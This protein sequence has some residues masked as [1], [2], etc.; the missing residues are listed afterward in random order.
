MIHKK[1]ISLIIPC[2]NEEVALYAML[3]K[4]PSFVDE[5]LVVDN[6]STDNTAFIAKTMGAKVISEKRT[7]N[8]V[9]YG[10]AHQAGMKR[11]KGDI[12]IALDGDNTYPLEKMKDI[13]LYMEKGNIDFVSCARFPLLNNHAISKIRQLGVKI[14]NYEV[15]A[16][17]QYP[18]RD[19]LSGMWVVKHEAA[20]KLKI[21][22]GEWNYSPEIKLAAIM[23]PEVVF[24]EYHI[25]HAVRFN[26]ISKQN[27][28]KTGVNHLFF[29]AKM[30]TRF[31]EF[32]SLRGRPAFIVKAFSWI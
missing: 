31:M 8:G 13:V 24:S 19:I 6:A 15:T 16:L 23:H 12:I 2:R 21:Q 4:I 18:I 26:G 25:A 30:R 22:S 28:W 7:V 27:I 10:Y 5:V 1:K 14:L 17:Y 20:K 32:P 3:R 11:A 29:I 9:G